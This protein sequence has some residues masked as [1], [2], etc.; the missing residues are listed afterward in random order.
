VKGA[1]D[2]N[3]QAQK[4]AC[5]RPM[6]ARCASTARKPSASGTGR[7]KRARSISNPGSAETPAEY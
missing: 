4:A 2:R 6:A 7:K 1:G 5:G 3:S